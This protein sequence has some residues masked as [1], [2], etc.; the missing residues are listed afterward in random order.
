MELLL[1][2]VGFS[3]VLFIM[4]LFFF[5]ERTSQITGDFNGKVSV[6]V[7]VRNEESNIE[8]LLQAL[9]HQNYKDKEIIVIDDASEDNTRALV[10]RFENN[11][12]KLLINKGTGKKSA[13]ETGVQEANG[14]IIICTDGD[15]SMGEEWLFT[16]VKGF[17]DQKKQLISGPVSY[18]AE[19]SF[20]KIQQIELASLIGTGAATISL[21]SP[22][23]CN[24]A[25]IAYRKSAF[26]R[27]NGFKENK[28]IASGDDEFLMHTIYKHLGSSAIDFQKDSRAIVNTAPNKTFKA[29]Y[30]Q[31]K[32]WA[33]KW[34]AYRV[35]FAKMLAVVVFLYHLFFPTLIVLGSLKVVAWSSVLLIHCMKLISQFIFLR[36]VL[37]FLRVKNHVFL[38]LLVVFLYDLYVIFFALTSFNK[39]Y[40]WKGRETR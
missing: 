1:L 16:M 36:R 5:W 19:S 30:H 22:S 20:E 37:S 2:L 35:P 38:F 21:G 28:Q 33:S 26:E 13:I 25:N 3:Y 24:G 7:A 15:C 14:E 34:G 40:Y 23:M 6:L 9:I 29:L 11:G 4:L 18:Y 39:G 10:T 32:R 12:V 17:S 31:R 27:V 8:A